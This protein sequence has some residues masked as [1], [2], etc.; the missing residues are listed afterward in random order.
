MLASYPTLAAQATHP[1]A[2]LTMPMHVV[3]IANSTRILYWGYG[4]RP[5]QARLW[6]QETGLYTLPSNQPIAIAPDEDIWSGANAELNDAEGTILVHGG[7]M[8]G[9]SMTADTE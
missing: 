9:G 7:F 8:T 1:V 5:D 4:Q 3:L 6:D 2:N